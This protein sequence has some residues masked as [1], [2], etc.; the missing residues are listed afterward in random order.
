V[1]RKHIIEETKKLSHL[2]TARSPVV[3][4]PQDVSR[5]R[6][7]TSPVEA[8]NQTIDCLVKKDNV[9]PYLVQM[10]NLLHF[11]IP[12]ASRPLILEECNK[13][14]GALFLQYPSDL[15]VYNEAHAVMTLL[16]KQIDKKH[17]TSEDLSDQEWE[18]L[19]K[20]VYLL[21]DWHD[22]I[23]SGTTKELFAKQK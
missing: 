21:C 16:N 15:K 20:T 9:Y 17:Q 12:L 3:N 18:E 22:Q 19:Q 5:Q 10:K 14:L 2:N 8:C 11:D 6:N 4:I 13:I 7:I 23:T 1:N